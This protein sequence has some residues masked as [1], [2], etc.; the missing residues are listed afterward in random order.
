MVTQQ[1]WQMKLKILTSGLQ[2]T[3]GHQTHTKYALETKKVNCKKKKNVAINFFFGGGGI[4]TTGGVEVA[5]AIPPEAPNFLHI[6]EP[7]TLTVSQPWV[8][9]NWDY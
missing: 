8:N 9:F 2:S 3:R 6:G 7:E 1:Y 5:P 4:F